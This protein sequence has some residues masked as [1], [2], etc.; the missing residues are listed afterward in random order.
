[1][2]D[3]PLA[4]AGQSSRANALQGLAS[5]MPVANQQA[6]Q[7]MQEAQKTQMQSQFAAQNLG[8]GPTS[9]TTAQAAGAQ[10]AAAQGAIATS[11]QQSNQN[12]QVQ[13]GQLGLAEQQRQASEVLGKRKLGVQEKQRQLETKLAQLGEAAKQELFDKN[14]SF[15]QDELGR[16]QFNNRQLLDWTLTKAKTQEE[17]A[18]YQQKVM[19]ASRRKTQVLQ[20]AKNKLDRIL[21]QGFEKE[22]N[23]LDQAQKK[24]LVQY[25]H[26]IM[27]KIEYDKTHSAGK[28]QSFIAGGTIVGAAVGAI[29]GGVGSEGT[30]AAEGAAIG[31]PIGG[32]VGG[33][34]G[35]AS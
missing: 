29:I 27:Q 20:A 11:A 24:A 14:M 23:D 6:A 15:Q 1:M 5:S 10:Q 8:G 25:R 30:G 12:Q 2:A 3:S 9:R 34:V 32:G 17:F 4:T 7:G 26:E 16:T 18:G 21:K 19:E 13:M 33:A 31:A 22:E 35:S 28:M